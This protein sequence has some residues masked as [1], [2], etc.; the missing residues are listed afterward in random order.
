MNKIEPE[1]TVSILIGNNEEI[2]S[3]IIFELLQEKLGDNLSIRVEK[4]ADKI[5]RY[6]QEDSF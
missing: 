6:I 2:L 1:K 3:E 4:D 5:K